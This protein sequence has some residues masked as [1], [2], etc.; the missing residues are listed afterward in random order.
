MLDLSPYQAVIFDMDGTLIDSMP[1]HLAAWQQT[2]AAFDFPFE[3][4]WFYQLGGQPTTKTAVM[5]KAKYPIEAS[6]E[7]LVQTKYGHYE[8]IEQ[9]GSLIA[10]THQVLLSVLGKKKVAIGTGSRRIHADELLSSNGV[11]DHFDAI[12]TANDVENHKPAPDTFL[13]AADNMGVAP[14]K[15]VVFEDT[16]LGVR[17]AQAAGMDCY[18]VEHGE[19]S[20]FIK[21]GEAVS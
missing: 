18:L 13:Q 6:E 9:K 8:A 11:I 3:P 17:A 2:A 19:I 20:R 10:S 7:T 5:L 14:A 21:A 16:L 12:V 1:S 15:C 4:E